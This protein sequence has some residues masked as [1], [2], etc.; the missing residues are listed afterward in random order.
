MTD[1]T[2]PVPTAPVPTLTLHVELHTHAGVSESEAA[3]LVKW[4]RQDLAAGQISSAQTETIFADLNT[5][6]EQRSPD[7]RTAEQKTLDQHFPAAKPD[8]FII[9]YGGPGEDV[10]MTPELKQ[11][12]TTAR[13][14]L[15]GTGLPRDLGNSLVNTIARVAQTTKDMTEDKLKSYGYV[16][17][18]K[19][20]HAYGATLEGKLQSAALMIHDLNL[21]QPGL[22][23]LL[24]FKG[25]GDSALVASMLIQH[26]ALY[27]ARRGH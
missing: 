27:H 4:T 23:G 2:P 13:A 8:E 9:R 6:L 18:A 12:D 5:P 19:L 25:I 22:K 24:R 21:K 3:M 20:E 17:F 26:A 15:S 7:T 1:V 10:V 16:E 14:W 11:F